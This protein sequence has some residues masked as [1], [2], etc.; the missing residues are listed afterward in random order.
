MNERARK[1]AS[2]RER[3]GGLETRE[4]G[5][6]QWGRRTRE[7]GTEVRLEWRRGRIDER[8]R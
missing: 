3:G 5:V 8:E 2:E 7:R 4:R 6:K 1:R